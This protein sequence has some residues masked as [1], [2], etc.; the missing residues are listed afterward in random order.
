MQEKIKEIAARVKEL[1]EISD[2]PAEKMAKDL[3][4]AVDMYLKYE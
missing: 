2:V 3:N 4:V 1:R